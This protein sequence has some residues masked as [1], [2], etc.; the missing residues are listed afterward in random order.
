MKLT[1]EMIKQLEKD[2]ENCTTADDLLGPKGVIKNLIRG[3]S[4]QILE[5]E[6]THHLGY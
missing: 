1:E 6:M 4:E 3:L 5:A 2:L